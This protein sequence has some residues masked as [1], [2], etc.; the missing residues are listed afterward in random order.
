MGF[1]WKEFASKV[2][3]QDLMVRNLD[4]ILGMVSNGCNL[5]AIVVSQFIVNWELMVVIG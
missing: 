3:D 4:K 1:N 2:I 5:E